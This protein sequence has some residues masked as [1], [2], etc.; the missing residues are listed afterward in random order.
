MTLR[1]SL[2]TQLDRGN[3]ASIPE[4]PGVHGQATDEGFVAWSRIPGGWLLGLRLRRERGLH[5]VDE[6]T[7]LAVPGNQ[8]PFTTALLRQVPMGE[9]V[10]TARGLAADVHDVLAATAAARLHELLE[11]WRI[12]ARSARVVRDDVAYAALA[13]RYVQLVA[14]GSHKPVDDLAEELDLSPVTVSL[15]LREARHRDLLTAAETGRPGGELT[16]HAIAALAR[17]GVLQG[18]VESDFAPADRRDVGS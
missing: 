18:D 1:E 8:T 11:P 5:A 12:D 10:A 13:A 4:A 16:D 2:Q 3:H 17:A 14:R 15:R 6:V 7:F 9:T